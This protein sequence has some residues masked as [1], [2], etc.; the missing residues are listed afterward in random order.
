MTEGRRFNACT[1]V[2]RESRHPSKATMSLSDKMLKELMETFQAELLEH[3][4]IVCKG[5]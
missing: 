1:A 3:L 4:T 5:E 2:L